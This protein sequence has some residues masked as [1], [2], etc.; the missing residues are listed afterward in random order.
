MGRGEEVLKGQCTILACSRTRVGFPE[1]WCDSVVPSI[2]VM[3][4][5]GQEMA[6]TTTRKAK[7]QNL[8]YRVC[9]KK[10]GREFT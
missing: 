5:L 6:F 9:I 1:P 4:S 2:A 3:L 7:V 10:L 8:E